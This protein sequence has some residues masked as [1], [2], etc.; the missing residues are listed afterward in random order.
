V[1]SEMCIRREEIHVSQVT[2]GRMIY[3][4]MVVVVVDMSDLEP[5][6]VFWGG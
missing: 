2:N 6:P 5:R 4:V 3:E 1:G